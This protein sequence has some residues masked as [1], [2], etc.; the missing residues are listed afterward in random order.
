MARSHAF[1]VN[2]E[3]IP[4]ARPRVVKGH[5]F[6][7][8]RTVDGEV[9]VKAA[10]INAGVRPLS[11]DVLLDIVAYRSTKRR[12]DVDNIGKLV[13]DGL[14]GVA[15]A[16]DSQVTFLTVEKRLDRKRPRTEVLLREAVVLPVMRGTGGVR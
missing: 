13:M 14:I 7:P 9:A 16:D 4:K 12:A 5:T 2:G 11:G 8:Q 15:F 3:P 6:T 10:A 1:V